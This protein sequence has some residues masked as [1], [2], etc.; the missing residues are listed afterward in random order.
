MEFEVITFESPGSA[1]TLYVSGLPVTMERED[2]WKALHD[3][4]SKHGLLYEVQLPT[5][6]QLDYGFIRYY[7]HNS[8]NFALNELHRKLVI[9]GRL[10]KVSDIKL[11]NCIQFGSHNLIDL[12]KSYIY[13]GHIY[14]VS[15]IH[16]V[17]IR[18]RYLVL[19]AS[20]PNQTSFFM[21]Q[22]ATN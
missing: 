4:F 11:E 14:H 9:G 2:K 8:A 7:S 10:I 22:N 3:A 5:N 6:E 13:S 18:W 21:L 12:Q 17:F 15:D 1:S 19:H 20:I 16:H